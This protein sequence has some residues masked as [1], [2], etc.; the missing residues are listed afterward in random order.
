[1]ERV[2]CYYGYVANNVSSRVDVTIV[3]YTSPIGSLYKE[4]KK[5]FFK[6][7]GFYIVRTV[8]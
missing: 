7:T 6:D 3:R 8:V 2:D 5:Y 1:V 4:D